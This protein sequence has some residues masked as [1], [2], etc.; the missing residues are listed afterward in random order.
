MTRPKIRDPV[1][2]GIC[3]DRTVLRT[4]TF[5]KDN[6]PKIVVGMEDVKDKGLSWARGVNAFSNFDGIF[7]AIGKGKGAATDTPVTPAVFADFRSRDIVA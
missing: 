5:K 4:N 3:H 2:M 6:V 7:G 1:D